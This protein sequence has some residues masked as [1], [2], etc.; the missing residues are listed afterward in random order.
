M[1]F[2]AA[3]K[4]CLRNYAVFTGPASRSEY[5]YFILFNILVRVF[6]T[7]IDQIILPPPTFTLIGP[8]RV[9]SG[10]L[11]AVPVAAV[12]VRRLNA[13]GESWVWGLLLAGPLSVN[14]ALT[15][16]NGLAQTL[17]IAAG[18]VATVVLAVV[19]SQPNE[20]PYHGR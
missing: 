16:M 5:W 20:S 17:T 9:L 19:S 11:L 4:S 1:T 2:C 12:Q 15:A 13:I 18:L 6:T 7:I 14:L 10:V 8:M 3:V